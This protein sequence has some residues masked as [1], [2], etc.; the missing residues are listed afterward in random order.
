MTAAK[1]R[2]RSYKRLAFFSHRAPERRS[3][4]IRVVKRARRVTL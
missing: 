2:K 3:H 1:H 4:R